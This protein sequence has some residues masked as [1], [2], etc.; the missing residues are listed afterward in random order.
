MN[1][2]LIALYYNYIK[3]KDIVLLHNL[4][5]KILFCQDQFWFA[6]GDANNIFD[7]LLKR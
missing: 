4:V 3:K 2:S 7:I 5:I 6:V 1:R